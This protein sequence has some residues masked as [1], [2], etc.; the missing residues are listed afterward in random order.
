[1]TKPVS[2]HAE[3]RRCGHEGDHPLRSRAFGFQLLR[4]SNCGKSIGYP[5]TTGWRAFWWVVATLTMA[6]VA[7]ANI[8]L[9]EGYSWIPAGIGV[10]SFVILCIDVSVRRQVDRAT[11]AG[12]LRANSDASPPKRSVAA[13]P[14]YVATLTMVIATALTAGTVGA[15]VVVGLNG[16]YDTVIVDRAA[17]EPIAEFVGFDVQSLDGEICGVGEDYWSCT[18]MHNTMWN[19]LCTGS[20]DNRTL[21]AR[22]TCDSLRNFVDE[23]WAR[24][25]TCGAGCETRTDVDG[26]WGYSYHNA[27]PQ[28]R[29]VEQPRIAHTETCYFAL[30][31]IKIGFC[32]RE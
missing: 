22:G 21:V 28:T 18:A 16:S 29:M 32:P 10:V 24:Y 15:L 26:R 11:I 27:V 4:C 9:H 1:M 23:A 12:A 14:L 7:G 25:E 13:S 19:S 6:G 30:G 20:D 31:A 5:L 3:C 8:T 17:E 2:A